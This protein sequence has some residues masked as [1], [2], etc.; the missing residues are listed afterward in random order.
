MNCVF[1]FS[2]N[3]E[4]QTYFCGVL[5]IHNFFLQLPKVKCCRE[6]PVIKNPM[7]KNRATVLMQKGQITSRDPK[8]SCDDSEI[9]NKSTVSADKGTDLFGICLFWHNID[10]NL[11]YFQNTILS[12]LPIISNIIL[13]K[14]WGL[15]TSKPKSTLCTTGK[16]LIF[17]QGY[18]LVMKLCVW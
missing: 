8:T 1:G 13:Q 11:Q 7:D 4:L 10:Q 9:N 18:I 16:I 3:N 15:H 5:W 2:K 6:R 17:W 14:K 12:K